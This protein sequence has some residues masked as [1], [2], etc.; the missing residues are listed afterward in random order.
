MKGPTIINALDQILEKRR[1]YSE[2]IHSQH[3][4]PKNKRNQR[5]IDFCK[6]RVE[7]L[8]RWIKEVK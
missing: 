1:I 5:K 4:L 7:T 2:Y 8:N 6:K 3:C